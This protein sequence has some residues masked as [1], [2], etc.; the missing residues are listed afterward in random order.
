[1][2]KYI[3]A[4]QKKYGL[5]ADGIIG[6]NTLNKLK[7]VFGLTNEQVAH[8]MGQAHVESGGFSTAYENLNYSAEG[9]VKI[10]PKYF[11]KATAPKYARNP[12]MIANRAY[13]NRMGNGNEASGMGYKFRG[14]GALQLT[15]YNNYKAFSTFIGKDVTTNPD[16][17]AEEFFLESAIFYFKTNNL[18]RLCGKVD[19]QTITGISK[20]I[21]LGNYNSK[22]TPHG[23]QDRINK[24]MYFYRM[25]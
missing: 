17:V 25:M 12:E 8:F 18:W 15:G 20:A 13:A 5:V 22:A 9:L 2:S 19:N 23:L 6:R 7:T 10:F 24:T 3:I 1:M 11:D 14:R 21:N 16:L 4:F